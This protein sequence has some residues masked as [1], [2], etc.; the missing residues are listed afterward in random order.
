L[1]ALTEEQWQYYFKVEHI[2]RES[3]TVGLILLQQLFD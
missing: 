3:V 2:V 1:N